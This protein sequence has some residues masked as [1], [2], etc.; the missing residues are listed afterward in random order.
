MLAARALKGSLACAQQNAGLLH[1]KAAK[2]STAWVVFFFDSGLMR[3]AL[4]FPP[5]SA[6][7]ARLWGQGCQGLPRGC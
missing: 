4:D 2:S 7:Q 5:A 6:V 3:R 1:Q